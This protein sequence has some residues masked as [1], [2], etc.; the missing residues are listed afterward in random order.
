MSAPAHTNRGTG[1]PNHSFH[2]AR[3]SS[4]ADLRQRG[5]WVASGRGDNAPSIGSEPDGRIEK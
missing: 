3:S 1:S 4:L 5:F 2:E